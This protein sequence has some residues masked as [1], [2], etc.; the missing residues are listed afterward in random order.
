MMGAFGELIYRLSPKRTYGYSCDDCGKPAEVKPHP[1]E[2]LSVRSR[3]WFRPIGSETG[4]KGTTAAT[5]TRPPIS[6]SNGRESCLHVR[7][8]VRRSRQPHRRLTPSW[9]SLAAHL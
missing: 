8:R 9:R 2:Q 6:K 1:D 3:S 5:T 7:V 4:P